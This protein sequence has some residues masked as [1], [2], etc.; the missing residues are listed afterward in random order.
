MSRLQEQSSSSSGI[1]SSSAT[2][3]DQ[4]EKAFVQR[5][6]QRALHLSNQFLLEKRDEHAH[7]RTFDSCD[8]LIRIEVECRNDSVLPWHRVDDELHVYELKIDLTA[9]PDS[10][11]RAMAVALQSWFEISRNVED[12]GSQYLVPF[13]RALTE[14]SVTMDLLLI[15]LR[16]YVQMGQPGWSIH[17]ATACLSQCR[18]SPRLLRNRKGTALEDS[19]KEMSDMLLSELLPFHPSV[20]RSVIDQLNGDKKEYQTEQMPHSTWKVTPVALRKEAI[21]TL[22]V[23]IDPKVFLRQLGEAEWFKASVLANY[24]QWITQLTVFKKDDEDKVIS[25]I[26]VK[27]RKHFD[28]SSLTSLSSRFETRYLHLLERLKR[29]LVEFQTA[30][31]NGTLNN[32]QLAGAA[33]AFGLAVMAYRY[34]RQKL[35]AL[36]R[37]AIYE[38]LVR[39]AK[40]IV[41]ALQLSS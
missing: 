7:D 3:V 40:E 36:L 9:N 11:N 4:A 17:V 23:L 35:L 8:D 33:T 12:D 27:A 13:S 38:A 29:L 22:I 37:A 5:S 41:E 34:H 1:A 14:F 18:C 28:Q 2:A 39:P 20:I 25:S 32:Y 19:L 30:W 24:E 10:Q 21:E 31:Q 26:L 16:F 6:F 15:L